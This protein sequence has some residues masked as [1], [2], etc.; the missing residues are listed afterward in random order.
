V[1]KAQLALDSAEVTLD[2]ATMTSPITGVVSTL[3]F[4]TGDPVNTNDKVVV[5]GKGSV[6]IVVE[7][8]EASV[9]TVKVGQPAAVTQPGAGVVP[10]KVTAVGLLPAAD[11]TTSATEYPVTVLAAPPT[12][13]RLHPGA[14]ASVRIT[15]STKN[16]VIVVPVSAVTRA[17]STGTISMLEDGSPRTVTV[18]IGAVGD[19]TI[20]VTRGLNGGET[21]VLADR[22]ATLPTSSS[23]LRIRAGGGF[24]GGGGG[25][26]GGA[27]GLGGGAATGPG[28]GGR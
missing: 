8:P 28:R 17:G 16:N 21:L 19:S 25:F 10:G 20:E 14:Q 22:T 7:V 4:A 13:A 2:A 5:I 15:L 11:A 18:T 26:G 1:T 27:A 6:Q 24:G 23:N 3:P 12:A 9:R